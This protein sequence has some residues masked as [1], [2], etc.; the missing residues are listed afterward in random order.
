MN[1]SKSNFFQKVEPRDQTRKLR[2]GQESFLRVILYDSE[3]KSSHLYNLLFIYLFE[4]D[5][6]L[7]QY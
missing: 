2:V 5:L 7:I 6:L 1:M 3:K 4:N